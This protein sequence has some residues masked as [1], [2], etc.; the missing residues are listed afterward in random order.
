M[1]ACATPVNGSLT[2]AGDC[3]DPA[4]AKVHVFNL[5]IPDSHTFDPITLKS[6]ASFCLD[7]I[8]DQT[9]CFKEWGYG[10]DAFIVKCE[11]KPKTTFAAHGN[12]TVTMFAPGQPHD[13]WC[14]DMRGGRNPQAYPCVGSKN[15]AR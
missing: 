4:T 12:K 10:P 8:C 1:D 6:D 15:Q 2:T 9:P 3:A 13:R 11:S 7:F 14:L 5:P